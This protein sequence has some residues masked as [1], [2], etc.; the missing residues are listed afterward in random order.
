MQHVLVALQQE[1]SS[2]YRILIFV[3]SLFGWIP[4]AVAPSPLC[5]PLQ[6][7]N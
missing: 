3:I 6:D 2:A 1:K 4:V 7:S 5:T